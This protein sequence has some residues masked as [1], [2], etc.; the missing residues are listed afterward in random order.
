MKLHYILKTRTMKRKFYL[1]PAKGAAIS[2]LTVFFP[3]HKFDSVNCLIYHPVYGE[4]QWPLNKSV[5]Q[6]IESSGKERK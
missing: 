5:E 2:F 3:R 6:M 1:N 4:N